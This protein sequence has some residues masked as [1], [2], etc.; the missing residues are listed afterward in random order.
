MALVVN[1]NVSSLNAQRQLNSTTN[2]M[3]TAMERLSSG[4]RIN[5]AADDAA[6]L[7]ISSRMTS[8]VKG[9]TMA[10]RN[11][12]DGISLAQTAEGAME[13]ATAM[14]QR[15]REL[16]VQA[17]NS[18]NN[19]ADRESLDDEVQQLKSE[20]E[21][22]ADTTR[23]NN[24]AILDGSFNSDI[25]IGDQVG[26]SM[27]IGIASIN[28]VN[29]GETAD[30]PAVA[31]TRA[32]LSLD[33]VSQTAADYQGKTFD[34]TVNGVTSTV[35]LPSANPSVATP[36]TSAAVETSLVGVDRT[37]DTASGGQIGLIAE[38]TVD[39]SATGANV[40]KVKV[41]DGVEQTITLRAA[42]N[43]DNYSDL[44]AIKASELVA[45]LQYQLD[46]NA[47]LADN[48]ALTATVDENGRLNLSFTNGRTGTIEVDPATA[49]T[50]TAA[51]TGLLVAM[52]GHYQ[53]ESST[54]GSLTIGTSERT[55]D[56]SGNE[57]ATKFLLEASYAT[58][59]AGFALGRGDTNATISTAL[60]IDIADKITELGY[61]SSE[62]TAT[63][64]ATALE[65]AIRDADTDA[66]TAAADVFYGLNGGTTAGSD[67]DVQINVTA[68]DDGTI[69]VAYAD[70]ADYTKAF[71][72]ISTHGAAA[73][74]F[75]LVAKLDK[76]AADQT[77][78]FDN[79]ITIDSL[80]TEDAP[81]AIS[82]IEVKAGT[83]DLS[84]TGYDQFYFG[85][86]TSAGL[87]DVYNISSAVTA[88]GYDESALTG[89]QL[90]EAIEDTLQT[91]GWVG[92]SVSSD[93][94]GTLTF[95]ADATVSNS[96]LGIAT[97]V[98]ADNLVFGEV[99][100]AILSTSD[101]THTEP[102]LLLQG[103]ELN[104]T[105]LSG[106]LVADYNIVING[107]NGTD[108]TAAS[109]KLQLTN[110]FNLS[111]NGGSSA[112]LT[113]AA[114]DYASMSDLATA[115][116]TAI[117]DSNL[118]S[119][120]YAVSVSATTDADGKQG[121][122]FSNA[123]GKQIIA[124]GELF[125]QALSLSANQN[126]GN[127][128]V[129]ANKVATVT[130]A[131]FNPQAGEM[132]ER[133]VDLSTA[134]AKAFQINVNGVGNTTIDI[135][136]ALSAAGVTDSTVTG[137][138]LVT[139]LNSAL[140]ADV[141]LQGQNAVTAAI[142]SDGMLT[143]AVAGGDQTIAFADDAGNLIEKVTDLGGTADANPTITVTD[144]VGII[145]ESSSDTE[146]FGEPDTT[147]TANEN[148]LGLTVG[149]RSVV[150]VDITAGTYDTMQELVD[151]IQT[152]I[153][154]TG[155]F[156]GADALTVSRVVNDSGKIGFAIEHAGGES[157]KIDGTFTTGATAQYDSTG[158]GTA[159]ATFDVNTV[160]PAAR[161]IVGGVDLSA[162]NTVELAVTDADT[163]SVV[164]RTLT[165]ASTDANVSF[166]DYASLVQTAAN[167]EFADDG[168]SFTA[169]VANSQLS[170][171]LDQ[172]GAKSIS[173]SGT[174]V[175]DAVGGAIVAAG[176][177]EVIDSDGAALSSMDDV[178]TAINE[179]LAS[180][181]A[182]ASFNAET[183]ELS[184]SVTDGA[185]GTNSV[186][187]ISGD[188]L[189][190]VQIAGVLAATGNAGN[191]TAERLSEIDVLSTDNAAEAILSIDNALEFVN[192]ERSNLGAIQNRLE[193]TVNNL[194]NIVENTS[195][196]RSRIQ[197]ADFA[198]EAAALAKY[199]VMQQAGTAM[200][201]QANAASQVVLSLL[202]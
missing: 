188:D 118:F 28:T 71:L 156:T 56:L 26:Q 181:G 27:S 4:K 131:S 197:D 179:D 159:D 124:S 146:Q 199:Q 157:V 80:K 145:R 173:L 105:D 18:I 198:A 51:A 121:L 189:A 89:A 76:I 106:A 42:A 12:N 83:V 48:N 102:A 200:L 143:L 29:L 110:T 165:L 43:T 59:A 78:D 63:Q 96:T 95:T 167:A 120:E 31:A 201:A 153:D 85:G 196:S 74:D 166:A 58:S 160:F 44:S 73:D 38:P 151:E 45:E 55:V 30:G 1:T 86:S 111:V 104:T 93:N 187:S 113:V 123:A 99:P 174:S 64:L 126:T 2:E 185:T 16:A 155:L 132:S 70:D 92:L 139:A 65:D 57:G 135:T 25:Q 162:D 178:V 119:G 107:A 108:T 82:P 109:T 14:L 24:K 77:E 20:I 97:G 180:A 148:A 91:G 23:F 141:N 34:V 190:S 117:D 100:D 140:S 11:A 8:Q 171:S 21:R 133:V 61:D 5:S 184:F 194:S 142:N 154:D 164:Q 66:G 116:Q 9:L 69:Q 134:A 22:I 7:A 53:G 152:Q 170:F 101:A 40:L 103:L 79:V 191:A 172:T 47:A 49:S 163:G 19:D 144:G 84:E 98:A 128:I 68:L 10:I 6:G 138:Q 130:A 33:G 161:P 32:E 195:A 177:N 136:S 87:G 127:L 115:V 168:Y 150:S 114:A 158:N 67:V 125:T 192:A 50:K 72:K 149:T 62:L 186:L 202:G 147:I 15:M 13:E 169:S 182:S 37:A 46:E 54:T 81:F 129:D 88:L 90:A 94:T 17:S 137:D 41:D 60:E 122:T 36:A 35:T 175:S 3:S 112:D 39:L 183:G 176:T 75:S 52:N 193:H